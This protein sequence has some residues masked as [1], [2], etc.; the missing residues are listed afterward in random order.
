MRSQAKSSFRLPEE[1]AGAMG[2]TYQRT[3]LCRSR[4]IC[5]TVM[6]LGEILTI[7]P[8]RLALVLK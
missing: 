1:S 4:P 8:L 6:L 2:L 3:V 5:Q 7:L